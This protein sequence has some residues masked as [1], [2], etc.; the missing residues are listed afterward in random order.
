MDMKIHYVG[1]LCAMI[2]VTPFALFGQHYT[3]Q[4]D[5]IEA[6]STDMGSLTSVEFA[7][8]MV[9][10]WNVGNSL[11]ASPGET[12]WGNPLISQK[13]MDSIK[14]AGFKSVRIPVAWSSHFSDASTF[15]IDQNFL[16]RVQEVVNYVIQA[17]MVAIINIHW[18]GGW[19]V[20]TYAQQTYVNNR[21]TVMW[22]QIAI[23]F[24]DY[25]NRL[26][27]A[28]MNEIHVESVYSGP[29]VEN[30][31]V[32]NGL[33]QAFVSTVR[34][35]GGRNAYRYL[36]VQG[37]NT[38]IDFT[39]NSFAVPRDAVQNRLLVEVH[40]YDPYDFTINASNNTVTQWGK[41]ATD[42]NKTETWANESYADAQF[43]KMKSKFIDK[44]YGVILGEYGVIARLNLGSAALNAEYAGYRRYYDEYITGSI[45]RNGLVPFYWDNGG[46]GDKSLGLFNRANGTQVYRDIIKAI[47][48]AA[49]ANSGSTGV[50]YFHFNSVPATFDVDQNYPNPFN[51]ATQIGY[52]VP[53]TG[54]VS[55]KVY[56]LLGQVVSTLIE[57]VRESGTYQVTFNGANLPSGVY[58]SR[59]QA[60]DVT[61]TKKMT[62]MK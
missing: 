40:Y 17:G 5:S 53:H 36:A 58:F 32:H 23:E 38:N 62:L 56:N 25:D 44:G 27:F 3:M 22:R 57:G 31:A 2:L 47:V 4:A 52:S 7:R 33:N 13:L 37:Y 45:V 28:G 59:L 46:T 41:N 30:S 14:A 24:R 61:I 9:P 1:T 26:L 19:M 55:L 20:P 29:T 18:D 50:N 11:E 49:K 16:S 35:T 54:L 39:Y 48:D 43:L 6:D 34:S 10:G 60:G 15:T 51:P 12:S 21:L 8:T 42:P